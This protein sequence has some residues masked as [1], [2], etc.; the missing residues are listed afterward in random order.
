M[1]KAV[2]K[3]PKFV[4]DMTDHELLNALLPKKGKVFKKGVKLED[5]KNILKQL[6]GKD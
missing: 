1:K 2:K 3:Q 4:P 5:P 6:R